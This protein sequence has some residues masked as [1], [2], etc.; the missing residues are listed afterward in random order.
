M[1][2]ASLITPPSLIP[3]RTCTPPQRRRYNRISSPP[4]VRRRSTVTFDATEPEIVSEHEQV[5]VDT[6]ARPSDEQERLGERQDEMNQQTEANDD[7]VT[8]ALEDNAHL[9]ETEVPDTEKELTISPELPSELPSE[10]STEV[11]SE[12]AQ[13]PAQDPAQETAQDPA[14]DIA[15]ELPSED[16][17]IVVVQ[18]KMVTK[19]LREL[20]Q[21]CTA[22]GLPI[23]GKK[24]DLMQRL[25]E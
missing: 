22:R 6:Q 25:S 9:K 18:D 17:D 2:P 23:H 3:E 10:L 21:L 15:T 19:S 13:D 24:S 16:G 1:M 5:D 4:P 20:R 11:V 12:A 7:D 8:E 14:D